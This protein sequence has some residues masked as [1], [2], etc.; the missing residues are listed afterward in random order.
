MDTGDGN[1]IITGNH[2]NED[3]NEFNIWG[4]GF[5]NGSSMDL[6][7]MDT[8]DCNNTI[9]G[10]SEVES[11][12]GLQNY[13]TIYTGNGN[14]TI[15]AAGKLS[16]IRNEG[17]INTANDRDSISSVGNV[18]NRGLVFLGDGN[19]SIAASIVSELGL[20]N[21]ALENFIAIDTGH[22]DDTITST[23]VIYNKGVINT[24]NDNDIITGTGTE[25]GI[26]NNGGR[27]NTGNGNDSFIADEGFKS[28]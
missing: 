11:G 16:G 10:F 12:E 19:D 6:R 9:A 28:G 17:T 27:I 8:G 7:S 15:N 14:D 23:G 22:G 21:R 20:P 3:E 2:I 4:V 5:V 1:D 18:S 25:Y 26:Y 24:G 13:T